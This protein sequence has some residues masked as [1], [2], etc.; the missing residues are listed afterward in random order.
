MRITCSWDR[1]LEPNRPPKN[2]MIAEG[3]EDEMCFNTY[4]LIP[5][6]GQT[7]RDPNGPPPADGAS[8]SAN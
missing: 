3:T 5:D 4:S 1:S 2:I 6:P 8:P 7:P